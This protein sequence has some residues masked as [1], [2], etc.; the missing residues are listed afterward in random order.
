M[1]CRLPRLRAAPLTDEDASILLWGSRGNGPDR[2]L[3]RIS[4]VSDRRDADAML[5]MT[6]IHAS[7]IVQSGTGD[8]C[9]FG[10]SSQA[11]FSNETLQ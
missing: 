9:Y 1:K 10:H 5:V 4:Q 11:E 6:E 3:W 8:W 7:R 2:V